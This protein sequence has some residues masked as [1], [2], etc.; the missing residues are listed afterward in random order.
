[1]AA[2]GND[3]DGSN[4][5]KP[6]LHTIFEPERSGMDVAQNALWSQDALQRCFIILFGIYNL[7]ISHA[8]SDL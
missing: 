2:A 8:L 7:H 3:S 5:S 6:R 1:M 4:E